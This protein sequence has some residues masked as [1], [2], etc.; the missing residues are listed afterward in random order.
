MLLTSQKN[1]RCAYFISPFSRE[2]WLSYMNTSAVPVNGEEH[3]CLVDNYHAWQL[4]T[5]ARFEPPT[6]ALPQYIQLFVRCKINLLRVPTPPRTVALCKLCPRFEWVHSRALLMTVKVDNKGYI[7][8]IMSICAIL[9]GWRNFFLIKHAKFPPQVVCSLS[10]KSQS[11][12]VAFCDE[13]VMKWV[14]HMGTT[15]RQQSIR[16]RGYST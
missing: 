16:S 9:S 7:T 12:Q 2:L 15:K 5:K 13:S 3:V 4:F 1:L 11:S 8:C 6:A 14:S 10:A